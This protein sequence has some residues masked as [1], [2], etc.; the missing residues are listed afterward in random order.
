LTVSDN[1]GNSITTSNTTISVDDAPLTDTTPAT[2]IDVTEGLANTNV[3][4]MTF[5]DANPSAPA[6][7]FSVTNLNWGGTLAGTN[8]AVTVVPDPSYSGSGS[9]WKVVADAVTYAE[10]GTYAVSLT[11]HDEDGTDVATSQTSFNVADDGLAKPNVVTSTADSGPGSLRQALLAASQNSDLRT[12]TFDIPTTNPGFDPVTGTFSIALLSSLPEIS[13]AIT[14]DGWSQPGFAGAPLIR[15]IGSQAGSGVNGLTITAGNSTV[16]GLAIVN[17]S[18]DGIELVGNGGNVIEGDYIGTDGTGTTG[19]GNE[20]NGIFVSGGSAGNLIGTNGDGLNDAAERNVVSG[21]LGSGV[22]L[23]GAGTDANV[24]A[25][26]YI[27]TDATGTQVLANQTHGVVVSAGA[28]FNVVGTN[29]DGIGDSAERNVISGNGF[30]GVVL[31]DSGTQDNAVAGNYIGTDVTGTAAIGN[32]AN[33]ASW[34]STGVLIFSDASRNRIGT[35]GDGVADA[36]ERNVISGNYGMGVFVG[37]G[38]TTSENVIAGNYIGTDASGTTALGNGFN[39]VMLWTG[40]QNTRIGADGNDVDAAAERNVISGNALSGIQ[41]YASNNNWVTGNDIGTDAGGAAAVMNGSH[42]VLLDGGASS[43]IIGTNGDGN[44]DAAERNVISGNGG[45]GVAI[46]GVGC[47]QNIVAGN[48]IGTDS[49]GTQAL[50]NQMQGVA[51]SGGAQSNIIGTNGDGIAD[52]AER[53]LISGNLGSGVVIEGAGTDANVIAGNYIGTDATG[54]QALANQTH[55]VIV[56]AGASFNIVGTNGDGVGDAAER[57]VISGNGFEGVVLSDSGTQDNAVAGNYIGTDVTGT[58][59]IGNGANPASWPSTG[60]LIFSDASRNRIGTNGD[61][62][63]DA[64][65]RNVISGN[66]G[67]GVFVGFGTTT[68]ENVIAGNYIGTD[69]SGGTALGNSYNGVMLW[70]GAQGTRIGA[71][72][73][74]VDAAGEGNVIAFNQNGVVILGDSTV[75]NSIRQNSIFSNTGLGID[76]GSDGVSP[77]HAGGPVTGPNRFENFPVL[78]LVTAG[79]TTRVVGTVQGSANSTLTIDFYSNLA[80]DPSGYGQGRRYLGSTVVSTDSSGN[81][82]FD[83]TLAVS[84]SVGDSISATATDA[85]GNTSEFS[86]DLMAVGPA[87]QLVLLANPTTG[88]AGVALTPAVTVAVEDQ[89]GKVIPGD[90]STV[91]LTLSSGTF[92]NGST[93]ATTQT[94]NGVATFSN[95]VI[96]T[97]GSYSLS[98]SDGGLTGATSGSF[99][100]SPA[101]ASRVVLLTSPTTGTAGVALSPAVTVAVEDQFNNVV[102]SDSSTV[103]LTLS[104]GTFANGSTT[105]TAQAVNGVATFSNVVINAAG[106]YTLAVSDGSLTG[107]ASGNIFIKAAAA[108]KLVYQQ[109]PVAGLT[110]VALAP[111]AIVAVEDQFGNLVTSD[112]ST[113]KL[114]LSSGTFSTGSNT[115]TAV[116]S[117]GIATFSNLIINTIGNYTLSASDGGLATAVSGTIS[118]T[119][120]ASKLVFQQAPPATGTAGVALSPVVTVA[121]EDSKGNVVTSDSSSTVTLTLSSG[122]FSNGSTTATAIVVNGVATFSG[123]VINKT[124]SYKLTASD[125]ALTNVISNSVVISSAAASQVVFQQA[126]P[127]AGTAGSSFSVK[128]AVEDQFGNVVTSDVSTVTLTLSTGTFSTGSSTATAVAS[129]GVATFN[130]TINTVG[131]Y[132][133]AA[134]DGLLAGMASGN[135]TISAAAANKLAFQQAPPATGTAGAALNVVVA[136]VDKY[137]NIVTTDSSTVTLTL[138]SGTFSNGTTTATVQ[139]VHGVATF[140]SLVINK[141]GSYKLTASDG[142]FAKLNSG[143]FVINAA[144]ASQLVFTK[145]PAK[146]TVGTALTAVTVAV[147]DQFGNIVTSDNST[148]TLSVASGPGSFTAASTTTVQFVNGIATFSNLILNKSGTY[149]LQAVDGL[150]TSAPSSSIAVK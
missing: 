117:G 67:M 123:L 49:N 32:G 19:F 44:G 82:T 143:N 62:V 4:L 28:S 11:V 101:P 37:F 81:A 102:T 99:T 129:G 120:T 109:A 94:V 128:V 136:V 130:L 137:G 73:S 39:G 119:G 64:A 125:G 33:P 79:N 50:A 144:A 115:A 88:T 80:A 45:D 48:S 53:N 61:G 145:V 42:G 121:V 98:A 110:G 132:S 100:V 57:N 20:G 17:F 5:S 149:T 118:I 31:T 113:V 35:N 46:D 26:N 134:S 89:F 133:L 104:S 76:L 116:A 90:S 150:L 66:Y 142:S 43:N 25:G 65:E 70:A 47:D 96:N 108:S 74:H 112:S 3:V 16:T 68:S 84:I 148:I 122:T 58:A 23:A 13:A 147:E 87:S 95:L 97:A 111:P 10:P 91:T 92:A 114:T 63:A 72:G 27:G 107:T 1:A 105:A 6:G 59:A 41:I 38:T 77:N 83:V 55:G 93:T 18:G 127:V 103:T 15:L 131:T 7:D 135:I 69:A 9:G 34:P 146:G 138:S 71:D 30:E 60:V 40:A 139:A 36:A 14:I 2:S 12:I 140:S 29:G 78:N 51:I 141:T 106:T 86:A 21:N 54:T 85:A 124:G 75:S 56:S 8:P 52:T 126:P 24:I 22:V